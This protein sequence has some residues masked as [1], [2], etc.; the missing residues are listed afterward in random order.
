MSKTFI[1][2]IYNWAHVLIPQEIPNTYL[3]EPQN[4]HVKHRMTPTRS[5]RKYCSSTVRKAAPL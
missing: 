5:P 2:V 4:A 1:A 3:S